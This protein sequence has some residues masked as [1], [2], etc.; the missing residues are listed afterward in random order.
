[1]KKNLIFKALVGILFVIMMVIG[2][3]I[4]HKQN[5]KINELYEQIE[6]QQSTI[7]TMESNMVNANKR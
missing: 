7:M 1:M 5:E 3:Q 2:G 4:I 6:R